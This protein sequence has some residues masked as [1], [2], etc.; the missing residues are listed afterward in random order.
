MILTQVDFSMTFGSSTLLETN[1][2]HPRE[3]PLPAGLMILDQGFVLA[4]RRLNQINF[5][6]STKTGK[7]GNC[8]IYALLDQMKFDPVH[9]YVKFRFKL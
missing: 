1:Q 4:R 2:N 5:T 9:K 8:M 7:D 6:T 3:P